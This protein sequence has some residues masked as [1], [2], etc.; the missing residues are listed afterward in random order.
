M[1]KNLNLKHSLKISNFKFQIGIGLFVYSLIGLL[2]V[3]PKQVYAS[4]VALGIYPPIIQ[5]DAKSPVD[6][7]SPMT[8]SNESDI[9]LDIQVVVRPFNAAASDDGDVAY[10]GKGAKI[11]PDPQIFQKMSLFDGTKNTD[12]ITLAPN[13]AKNLE[14]R[15]HLPVDEPPGDYYFSITFLS[16][17]IA[18]DHVTGSQ[19]AGGVS[20]NVLLSIGPKD[21]TTGF[22]KDFSSPLFV[23]SGP[24]P[25]TVRV[26]NTSKHFTAPQGTILVKNMFGQTI[27]K[28]NLQ[29][30]NVLSNSSRYMTDDDIN[31]ERSINEHPTVLWP[32]KFLLGPYSAT[33]T[34]ALSGEG[35][36]YRRTI[37]FFALPLQVLV[38]IVLG[39]ILVTIVV[40][41][42]RKRLRHNS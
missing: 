12:Q 24:V 6:I 17:P 1:F 15:I 3:F 29:Q 2:V 28:V 19:I 5:I 13:Q 25:F 11:A 21:K 31:R 23:E 39:I 26:A 33:L 37:Y 42:V 40:I 32:E 8:L 14:L 30:D 4:D 27:G 38:G 41:R 7:Q 34:V 35:P 22:V 9:P 10:F 16:K 36:L 20:T 18:T